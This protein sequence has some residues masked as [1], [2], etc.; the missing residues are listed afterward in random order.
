MAVEDAL[1]GP[2]APRFPDLWALLLKA[3]PWAA[4]VGAAPIAALVILALFG[5][6]DGQTAHLFQTRYLDYVATSLML[7]ALVAI[8]VMALGAGA[9]WLVALHRFPG[10]DLFDLLLI[11][12][13]AAPAYVLAYAYADLT[14]AAGPLQTLVRETT[15]WRTG[16]YWFPEVRGLVGAAF[17]FTLAL[18]PYVY[19]VARRAFA[20]QARPL[21]EAGRTLG[22]GPIRGVLDVALPLA[23][24]ALIAGA[25]LALIETLA[26]YG[27]VAHLGA[28][29]LTFGAMRA[30]MSAGEPVAAARLAL[31]LLIFC[32][33]LLFTE[34]AARGRAR[35]APA[36]RSARPTPPVQLRGWKGAGAALLCTLPLV[37]ALG[38]PVGRL[39]TLAIEAGANADLLAEALRSIGLGATAAVFAVAVALGLVAGARAGTRRARPA[40]AIAAAGYAAPGAVA[41]LGALALLG[42]VQTGLDAA[43][44]GLAPIVVASGLPVLLLAYQTRFAA[45]AIGPVS[46]ALE[47]VSPALDAAA[48]TL[49]APPRGV[50]RR[51][52]LPL[53]LGGVVSGALLV[54]VE[55]L[56]EL[57][58]TMALSPLNFETLAV[59]AHA[60]A[61]DER[62][63]Q[64]AAPAL[65]LVIAALPATILAALIM[66]RFDRTRA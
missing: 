26:D 51:V 49:G 17:V 25:A 52:H 60:Y 41:A 47:R 43:W 8:G 55:V 7:A 4:L 32:A 6:D 42:T 16:G 14:A 20:E 28:P 63:A 1:A 2:R 38:V 56:K 44:G 53:A 58:A 15:G 37:F 46:A 45:A 59:A 29:T 54:F 5:S 9:A 12:P 21:M 34:R 3:A 23:R 62:L 18:Y 33:A 11:L 40:L 24:P 31:I 50:A 36:S 64:A 13:L 22:R 19:V 35:V 30:W 57:P 10:R 48:R 61:A 39:A 27:A 65:A 66:R